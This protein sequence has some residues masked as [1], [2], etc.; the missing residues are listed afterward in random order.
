MFRQ[1]LFALLA[2]IVI[3]LL[4]MWV[5]GGG[6]RRAYEDV[7]SFAVLPFSPDTATGFRLPW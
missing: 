1:V 7:T 4:V 5:I 6:P 2:F 3:V